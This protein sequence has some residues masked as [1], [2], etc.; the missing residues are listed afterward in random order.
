VSF[1]GGLVTA[2]FFVFLMNQCRPEYSATQYA[3]LSSLYAIPTLVAGPVGLGLVDRLGYAWLFTGSILCAVPG[4]V[5]LPFVPT[6]IAAAR[7][8]SGRPLR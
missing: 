8:G 3:L 7:Q 2:G 4:V 1:C 6:A 5:L